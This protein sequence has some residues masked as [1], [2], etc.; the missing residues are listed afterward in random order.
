M[1]TRPQLVIAS[2]SQAL[3]DL[4]INPLDHEL[5]PRGWDQGEVQQVVA[6]Q[7]SLD[8]SK[9]QWSPCIICIIKPLG[10]VNVLCVP[11]DFPFFSAVSGRK[12]GSKMNSV[13]K[14]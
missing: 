6:L 13:P 10:V 12:A 8:G 5:W 2:D 7:C 4:D 3:I 9:P 11:H 1:S 14:C